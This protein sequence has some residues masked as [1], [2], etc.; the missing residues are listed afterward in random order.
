MFE[1]VVPSDP[2]L[3]GNKKRTGRKELPSTLELIGHKHFYYRFVL[4]VL[5]HAIKGYAA[6]ERWLAS[7]ATSTAAGKTANDLEILLPNRSAS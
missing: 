2:T 5:L 1:I 4:Q 7:T 6:D 3:T